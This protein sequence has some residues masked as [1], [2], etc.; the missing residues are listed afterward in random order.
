MAEDQD[1][2]QQFQRN[3][4][5][6]E[7]AKRNIEK[8]FERKYRIAPSEWRSLSIR[9]P[10]GSPTSSPERR[11]AARMKRERLR[12]GWR[13]EDLAEKLSDWGVSLHSSAIAK[14]ELNSRTLRFNEAWAIASV[15][16]VSMDR[17]LLN[18]DLVDHDKDAELRRLYDQ[19]EAIKQRIDEM[20]Q[21]MEVAMVELER[22]SQR[23]REVEEQR[24]ASQ[25]ALQ[26]F[27]RL[28]EDPSAREE[29]EE[30]I[31][32]WFKQDRTDLVERGWYDLTR[33]GT[34]PDQ[35]IGYLEVVANVFPDLAGPAREL[36]EKLKADIEWWK[37][38]GRFQHD[39][40][41]YEL[42][43]AQIEA[44]AEDEIRPDYEPTD[45][46]LREMHFAH[47][48]ARSE[49]EDRPDYEPTDDELREMHYAEIE[50]RERGK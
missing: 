44:H 43:R 28:A 7:R 25:E 14:I 36:I 23:V 15:L 2:D 34:D 38:A 18:D 31:A 12:R 46:E 40:R 22:L 27:K 50:E 45:D 4:E 19:R 47:L 30:L 6:A 5:A 8:R 33:V 1:Q 32:Y 41:M 9:F 11:F 37:E 29:A 42:S 26:V 20:R 16:D 24:R 39:E 21:N 13:Q 35:L 3:I 17:M 49:D 10:E 48:E